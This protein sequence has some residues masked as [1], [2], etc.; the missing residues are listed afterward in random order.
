MCAINC[1]FYVSAD[2][3]KLT[4]CSV[5]VEFSS[6]LYHHVQGKSRGFGFVTFETTEAAEAS[7][8]KEHDIDG[9]NVSLT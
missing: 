5:S 1:C 6:S 2:V 9:K 4:C 3:K 8:G 7:L